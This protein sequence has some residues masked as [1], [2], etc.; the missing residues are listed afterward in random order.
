[1]AEVTLHQFAPDPGTESG[2]PFCVK[3]HRALAFKG[4]S[5]RP[6]T[7]GS[8]GELKRLNP[9]VSK[10]PVLEWDGELVA[11]STRIVRFLDAKVPDPPLEP[12]DA[13]ARAQCRLIEDWA[14]EALYWFP[15]YM[16]WQ[17]LSNFEPFAERAF[18]FMPAPVRWVVPKF[19]IRRG[20][21]A[22]LHGQG[23][24]RLT[25]EQ[26]MQRLEENL[27]M[28]EGLL[29]EQPFL[30]GERATAA[31]IS[32]FGPLRQAALPVHPESASVISS[33]P[34]VIAWLKRVDQATAGEHTVAF[35]GQ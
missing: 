29:G 13:A 28:I 31:D 22:S 21:L 34:A 32:V 14:D 17:V 24:G 27:Q 8:P 7:V 18:G 23:T 9:G 30:C 6:K 26:L 15:V 16:R 1:M 3:V 4:V 10:V 11:D 35:D 20:V 25:V 33:H 12:T 5:Y 19:V 2:S